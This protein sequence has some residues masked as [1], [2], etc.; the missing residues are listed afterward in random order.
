MSRIIR[1]HEFGAPEAMQI[2]ESEDVD[3]AEGEVRLRVKAIWT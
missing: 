1:I 2:E 3:P